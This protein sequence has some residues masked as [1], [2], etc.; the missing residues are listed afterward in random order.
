MNQITID[1]NLT[2]DSEIK[3][4]TD[5]QTI[6]KFGM[7]NTRRFQDKS[8]EWKDETLFITVKTFKRNGDMATHLLKG[9]PVM[10]SGSI[11]EERW[12]DQNGNNKSAMVIMANDIFIKQKIAK[13]NTTQET[14]SAKVDEEFPF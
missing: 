2:K 7:A 10:V 8:G 5:K 14:K 9:T 6:V 1:G 3:V 12:T 13:P 11:K 4:L